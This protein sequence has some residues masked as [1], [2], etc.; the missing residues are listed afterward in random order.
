MQNTQQSSLTALHSKLLLLNQALFWSHFL[1]WSFV[2]ALINA[3]EMQ[4]GIIPPHNYSGSKKMF[5]AVELHRE[6]PTIFKFC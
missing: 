5:P 6:I 3:V 2:F 1:L 4:E